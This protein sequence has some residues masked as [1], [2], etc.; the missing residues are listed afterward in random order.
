M[1]PSSFLNTDIFLLLYFRSRK[2]STNGW[3][4]FRNYSL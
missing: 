4:G 1:N 2:I 3:R